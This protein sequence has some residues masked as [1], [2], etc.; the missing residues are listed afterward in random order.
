VRPQRTSAWPAADAGRPRRLCAGR[1]HILGCER[2]TNKG[3]FVRRPGAEE[4][5]DP[6]G[7]F[8]P[9]ERRASAARLGPRPAGNEFYLENQGRASWSRTLRLDGRAP[10]AAR[11]PDRAKVSCAGLTRRTLAR[12]DP[13]VCPFSSCAPNN[14]LT[15]SG[16]LQGFDTAARRARRVSRWEQKRS[17]RARRRRRGQPGIFA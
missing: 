17:R 14:S 15:G 8:K 6:Y 5:H 13:N 3:R 9:G 10:M 7:G 2:L 1:R 11:F 4:N 12:T 16:C